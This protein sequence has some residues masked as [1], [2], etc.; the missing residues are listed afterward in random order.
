MNKDIFI[1]IKLW[2]VATLV[3]GILYPLVV[4]GIGKLFFPFSASGGALS[5]KEQVVGCLQIGQEW[6][7]PAFFWGRPSERPLSAPW[8]ISGASSLSPSSRKLYE[9]V[10]QRKKKL[11][12]EQEE[13]A[14]PG[15]LLFASASGIDPHLHRASLLYQVP[16][17]TKARNLTPSQ[18]EALTNLVSNFP[19]DS[20]LTSHTKQYLN[21]LK[22][23]IALETQFPKA[24]LE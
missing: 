22:L 17:I 9:T 16:R 19:A 24:S 13:G 2:L 14:V 7:D 11:I 20:L 15:D 8:V 6:N 21:V 5:F 12:T 10:M 3:T 23:N 4:F 18:T 1:A